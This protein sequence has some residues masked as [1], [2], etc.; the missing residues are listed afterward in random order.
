MKY[1]R[2][3]IV[4]L[5]LAMLT[6]LGIIAAGG[7]WGEWGLDGIRDRAGFVPDGMR[8]NTAASER[9]FQDYTVPGLDR[10]FLREGIGTIAA[11]IAGALVTALCAF[12]LVRI[13]R[14]GGVS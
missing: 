2:G 8:E 7:A 12:A 13:T 4:L 14:H 6:P 11:A 9:P 10:G 1:R 3:W 5:A